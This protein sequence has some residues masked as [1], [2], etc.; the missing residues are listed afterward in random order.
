MIPCKKL[1]AGRLTRSSA[2]LTRPHVGGELDHR[3]FAGHPA[4]R[5]LRRDLQVM[6]THV[7]IYH[8]DAPHTHKIRPPGA[9]VKR[10]YPTRT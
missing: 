6:P 7:P 3:H 9:T 5:A 1:R 8:D 10:C 2:R 4:Q